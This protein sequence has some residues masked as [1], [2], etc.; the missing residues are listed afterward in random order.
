MDVGGAC[1]TDGKN[2]ECWHWS[3]GGKGRSCMSFSNST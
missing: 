2:T 1:T 3:G